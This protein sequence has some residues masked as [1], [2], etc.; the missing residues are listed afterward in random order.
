[1]QTPKTNPRAHP[2]SF[3]LARHSRRTVLRQIPGR[4]VVGNH[5]LSGEGT[6]YDCDDGDVLYVLR[7]GV[8]HCY[9]SSL[10]QVLPWSLNHLGVRP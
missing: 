10:T 5:D 3:L 9:K 7:T 6:T 8:P 4:S 2:S 1:M